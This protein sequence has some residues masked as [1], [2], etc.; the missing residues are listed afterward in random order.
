MVLALLVAFL[1]G[2]VCNMVNAVFV[3]QFDVPAFIATLGMQ[4]VA[5]GIALYYTGGA[6]ILQLGKFV[7]LGQGMVGPFPVPVLI[8]L[9]ITVIVWY[10]FNHT[11]YGRSLYAIGGNRKAAEASGINTKKSIFISY[12]IVGVLAGLAG[13]IFMARNHASKEEIRD[14]IVSEF[15]YDLSRTCD[16]IRPGY[17][18]VESCQETVP[19]AIT[20]FLEGNDFEDVIRT[21]VSLGGDCDTLTCIAGSIAEAFYGVPVGMMAECQSRMTE[22]MKQVMD[23]FDKA[24]GRLL[25]HAEDSFGN[26][27]LVAAMA[28][29]HQDGGRESFIRVLDLIVK[30]IAEQGEFILPVQLSQSAFDMLGDLNKVKAGDTLQAAEEIRMKPQTII[31]NNGR[32]WYVVFT[33]HNEACKG[34]ASSSIN[35]PMKDILEAAL[36]AE[37]KEGLIIN[38]WENPIVLD[39]SMLKMVLDAS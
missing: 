31:D 35:Q 8:V 23:R 25:R 9:L 5:R 33:D 17:H 1:V 32:L 2:I 34:E 13:A 29:A 30:R 28:A 10:L 38:P 39:K 12:A 7:Q 18:H 37:D 27:E 26:E 3:A 6:N 36:A 22:D 4:Q 16:E 19:E 11:R 21:A 15:G 24:V 14:Y 20:A